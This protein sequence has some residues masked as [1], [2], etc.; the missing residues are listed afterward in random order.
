MSPSRRFDRQ[1]RFTPLGPAG[2]ERLE[3]ASV[4]IVGCGALG[5]VLA[6]SL[7]RAGIGSLTLID[8]DVVEETNLPR[9]VLFNEQHARDATPKV[10][11]SA[12]SLAPIGGPTRLLPIAAHLDA[13]NIE[14][15]LAGCHIVLD[16][17]DNLATR[18]LLNDWSISELVPWIYGGAVASGGLVLPVLPGRGPCLRCIF[19]DPPPPGTLPTCDTAGVIQP[20]V[21]LVASLQAGLALRILV[22]NSLQPDSSE[23]EQSAVTTPLEPALH[24]LDAWT[25]ELRR[26][27]ATRRPDCP[28]CAAGEFPFLDR[29]E[30]SPAI[31][32]CGRRA[33]QVFTHRGRTPDMV[34]L[35]TSLTGLA[36]NLR[37]A[38]DLL[39]FEVEDTAI[40]LFPDGRALI[41]GTEDTGQALALYDRYIG[42]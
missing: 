23:A 4:G 14:E 33:V 9:Q 41:E 26:L 40:T 16:G 21:G 34:A 35:S 11:A 39:R 17:T 18:Y 38:G 36:T 30:P 2:Q 27:T 8:R 25:G 42:S 22:E 20:A 3:S 5:G 32:L 15:H 7:C 24:Q 28:C 29:E 1:T 6:Q 37:R 10:T 13:A 19:P 12:E 31:T